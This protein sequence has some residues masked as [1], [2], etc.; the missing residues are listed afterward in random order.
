MKNLQYFFTVTTLMFLFFSTGYAQIN[1]NGVCWATCNVDMPATFAT[2]PE[3]A[4]MFYQWGSNVGWSSTDPL[5]ASDGINTWRNLSQSGNVW[6]PEK[7]PCPKG[8]R[9]P[10]R[11]EFQN[12]INISNYWGNLNGIN[13]RF[14]GNEEPFLFFPCAGYRVNSDG[15]LGHENMS[16]YYWS[17]TPYSTEAYSL[18]FRADTNLIQSG[19]YRWNGLSIRCVA[20]VVFYAN[21]V[22]HSDLPDTTFCNKTVYFRAEMEC[23]SLDSLKWYI[24][25]VEE[26]S[27][28]DSLKW[29]RDFPNG[30]YEI[31]M[32]AY[33]ENDKTKTITSTLKVQTLWIKMRNIRY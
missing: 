6:L 11:Q 20:D 18:Y 33:F 17:C 4:G 21:N 15:T 32:R 16:G 7:N 12:L 1:I 28:R 30:I 5:I 29:Y 27:A 23:L 13:G 9:V 24:S 31:E 19:F 8:W 25:G 10:T 26:V 2:N 14:F 3:D 22:Y